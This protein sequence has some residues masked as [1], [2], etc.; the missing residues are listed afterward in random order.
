M[1]VPASTGSER[2]AEDDYTLS[3]DVDFKVLEQD[4]EDELTATQALNIEISKAA[5]SLAEK[6]DDIDLEST[7]EASVTAESLSLDALTAELPVEPQDPDATAEVTAQ[8]PTSGAAENDDFVS[9]TEV[10][11]INEQL[12]AEMPLMTEETVE[13]PKT[14]DG[15]AEVDVESATIDTKKLAR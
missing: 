9:E 2:R 4:Y 5:M 11:S 1:A 6:M 8:L 13:M 12:T 14:R 3:K 10:T 15:A 7:V